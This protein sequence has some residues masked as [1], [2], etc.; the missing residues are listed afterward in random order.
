MKGIRLTL[1]A[2]LGALMVGGAVASAA[3]LLADPSFEDPNLYTHDG[4]PFIGSW[5]GFNGSALS[6]SVNDTLS[7]R[8]G[9]RDAHLNITAS[10][11]DFSGFFQDVLVTAGVSYTW[12]GFHKSVNLNPADYVTEVRFEWRNS[13]SN[14]EV[15]RNQILPIATSVYS[16]FSVTA[17]APVGADTARVVYAIQTF[18]DTGTLNTGDVFVDDVSLTA[19]PEPSTLAVLSLGGL[20]A[21]RRRRLNASR[22]L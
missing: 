17:V 21:L 13:V 14:T 19:V 3:N 10:N 12:S 1:L 9:Q 2:A 5:E 8:T 6:S 15:S 18:S 22:G 11:N 20:A 16:P 4:P 7:P